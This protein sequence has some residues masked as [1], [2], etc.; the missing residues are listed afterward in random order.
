[1][2]HIFCM[3][4]VSGNCRFEKNE[5]KA[6]GLP[7]SRVRT[8]GASC[9]TKKGRWSK[10]LGQ[11]GKRCFCFLIFGVSAR[12]RFGRRTLDGDPF[13]LSR[14]Q[15]HDGIFACCARGVHL[16]S[17][18]ERVAACFGCEYQC[19][20]GVGNSF[21][22]VRASGWGYGLSK[23]GQGLGACCFCFAVLGVRTLPIER[24]Q[25]LCFTM[26]VLRECWKCVGNDDEDES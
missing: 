15:G 4:S 21:A 2:R 23:T 7:T 10:I 5:G 8:D 6:R 11:P 17:A 25:S 13:L 9:L 3:G 14:P 26:G 20:K 1:M 22:F 16:G 12:S 24:E 18:W 19:E